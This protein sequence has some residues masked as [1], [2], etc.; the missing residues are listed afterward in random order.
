MTTVRITCSNLWTHAASGERAPLAALEQSGEFGHIHG[1]LTIEIGGRR[2]PHLGFFGPDDACLN[3]WLV[4][5]R[6]VVNAIAEP[7]GEYIFDEGEQGQPAFEFSRIGDEVSLSIVESSLSDGA[8]DAEWQDVRCSYEDFRAAVLRFEEEL[9]NELRR[10]AP[11]QWER[12]WPRESS[13]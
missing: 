5:L 9:R 10:Q 4:E 3:T 13:R 8:A 6:N 1:L 7:S 2:V 11:E 12:W